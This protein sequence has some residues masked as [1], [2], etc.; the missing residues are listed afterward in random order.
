[1]EMVK[2]KSIQDLES[3]P[4][5]SWNIRQPSEDDIREEAIASG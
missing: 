1:M 2:V 5:T 3:L 4:M